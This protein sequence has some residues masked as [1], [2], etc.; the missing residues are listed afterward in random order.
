MSST[1]GFILGTRPEIIKLSPVVRACQSSDVPFSLIHTG[2]HYSEELDSVFFEQL[3]LPE[4]EYNLGIGSSSHGEQTGRM[5]AEIESV[6][7]KEQR[8]HESVRRGASSC[9]GIAPGR[10]TVIPRSGVRDTFQERRRRSG[11]MTP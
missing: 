2:Q 3:D 1:I 5:I 8:G 9:L 4:P 11:R 7:E 6:L 10:G